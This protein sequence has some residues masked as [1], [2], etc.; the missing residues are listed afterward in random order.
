[1]TLLPIVIIPAGSA[2]AHDRDVLLRVNR[3]INR[4]YDALPRGTTVSEYLEWS[5][6]EAEKARPGPHDLVARDVEYYLKCRWEVSLEDSVV[7]G[8]PKAVG[9]DVLNLV[10]N[11]LKAVMIGLGGEELM[12]TDKDVPVASPGGIFWGHKGCMDGLRDKGKAVQ[13]PA[14][15]SFEEVH[16]LPVRLH[17]DPFGAPQVA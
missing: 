8:F 10:Y 9:G 4:A 15:A 6:C 1:M 13:K 2:S 17:Q 14:P 16:T 7:T 12:R 11:G 3:I 5:Q